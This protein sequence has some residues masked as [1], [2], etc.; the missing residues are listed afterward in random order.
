MAEKS[1]FVVQMLVGDEWEDLAE[2]ESYDSKSYIKAMRH[3]DRLVTT[4]ADRTRVRA[5][6]A[7]TNQK[8]FSTK[9]FQGEV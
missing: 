9:R 3:V 4:K 1:T 5:I 7:N 6:R 8:Y 2:Y